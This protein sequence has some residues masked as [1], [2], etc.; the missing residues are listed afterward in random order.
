MS[1][2]DGPECGKTEKIPYYPLFSL[3]STRLLIC[4]VLAA[5][6]YSTVSMRVNLSMAVVCM[7]N[8]TAYV[9]EYHP[10][11]ANESSTKAKC[12]L[13][14]SD[15]QIVEHAG[16]TGDLL[17]SPAMQSV[18]L[19]ATFY[20]GIAT[21]SFA[22]VLADRYGPKLIVIALTF[23]YIIVTLLTPI[24]AQHSYYAFFV[25]RVI[26]GIGEG[27][28]FPCLAS[29]VGK[30]FAPAEKS[31]VAA[32]YTSGNQIAASTTSL[33]SS[34]LCTTSFGWPS[35]FYL[36][37]AVGCVWVVFFYL[38]V[39]NSP[40][41][42]RFISDKERAYL[43]EYVHHSKVKSS[44][45]APWRSILTSR[46]LI[47]AVLCAFTYNTQ[48]SLFHAF[49]PTFLKE[50]LMLPLHMNGFYSM[51][52]FITQLISK[53]I[54]GVFADYLKRNKIV[55]HTKCAKIFQSIGS[56]GSAFLL[57][58]IA[59]IPSCENPYIALPLL[60]LYGIL[61]SAGICGFFTCVL[62]IAPPFSGTITS[63]SMCF[64]MLGNITG[65]M[66]IGMVTKL[67]FADKWMTSF[68]VCSAINVIAGT[69]FLI[70]GSAEVQP[71]AKVPPQK[72]SSA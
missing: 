12:Q 1:N 45:A 64:G 42:N 31:T 66:M 23:D 46:P 69:I 10:S 36:Y 29:I 22:G 34:Y 62:C 15:Q 19:S 56:F 54:L 2:S 44:G 60:A 53:N 30:W 68:L 21:I 51:T 59:T 35:I 52:P 3:K 5:G 43:A 4:L 55:G 40:A 28:M 63:M 6:L 17:W 13:L 24:L 72:T 39:S 65:P 37:G 7:V 67:G 41:N 26:M 16:Y 49:L 57:I 20:G 33:I 25:S 61:F 50:E 8:S 11:Y 71:W 18:I 14:N 48:A 27:F 70:F 32:L 38:I 47:A 9:A 58:A